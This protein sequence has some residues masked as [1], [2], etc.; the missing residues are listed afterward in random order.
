MP[1]FDDC[2]ET[3]GGPLVS[4]D[5]AI[6]WGV[7]ARR[8]QVRIYDREGE[9][10]DWLSQRLDEQIM[11]AIK[12][13][14]PHHDGIDCLLNDTDIE[15][16]PAIR[17]TVYFDLAIAIGLLVKWGVLPAGAVQDRVVCGEIC[18]DG[19]VWSVRGGM[20]IADAVICDEVR[21]LL[22]PHENARQATLAGDVTVIP[23]RSLAEAIGHLSEISKIMPEPAILRSRSID[24]GAD[25]DLSSLYGQEMGKRALEV[26]AAGGH[27]MVLIGPSDSG[28]S[29][30]ARRLP[31]ILPPMTHAE[32]ITVTRIH[33][34]IGQDPP[35]RLLSKR[36][37]RCP[38][39]G[40]DGEHM[41]GKLMS[42]GD[43][44]LLF[45]GEL[46]FAHAGVL[47]LNKLHEFRRCVLDLLEQPMREGRITMT[48][49][50]NPLSA[51]SHLHLPAN[52]MLLAD[53]NSCFCG[54]LNDAHRRCNCSE[55]KIKRYWSG[56]PWSMLARIDM[57]VQVPGMTRKWSLDKPK[58]G[59]A[60][61]ARRVA[62]AREIQRQRYGDDC[63]NPINA[64]MG[65]DDAKVH[66]NL[67][68]DAVEL[69][70]ET[71]GSQDIQD[72]SLVKVL[73]ISRTIADLD[74]SHKI[75]ASHVSEA[76]EYRSLDEHPKTQLRGGGG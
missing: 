7:D 62:T 65:R 40:I 71:F 72:D 67:R 74:G 45:P 69:I 57:H 46:S 49:Y 55:S 26:A 31:G 61:V 2:D 76:I 36:P 28:R 60:E 70:N 21:E 35:A 16:V 6:P 25:Y 44:R 42:G 38:N 19:A 11:P 73:K 14:Y 50:R 54:N 8:V 32:A 63:P 39:Y 9:P 52:F 27:S 34:A 51:A 33:S 30:L 56:A 58:E 13:L 68:D 66:C 17:D 24:H 53:M 41:A 59:S 23:V 20:A 43:G 10:S 64:A 3:R 18:S 29:A 37:F 12:R 22:L 75:C 1:L 4:V 48:Y 15:I 5:T 47:F